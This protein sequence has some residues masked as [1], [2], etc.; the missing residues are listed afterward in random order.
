MQDFDYT[1][2]AAHIRAAERMRS[3]ALGHLLEQAARGIARFVRGIFTGARAAVTHRPPLA[4][5]K[6]RN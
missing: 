1:T 2:V 3:E 6:H 5:A 4:G